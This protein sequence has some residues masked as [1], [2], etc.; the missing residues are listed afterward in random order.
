VIAW[1]PKRGGTLV[2]NPHFRATRS[3]AEGYPD[4]IEI[5]VFEEPTVEKR[6]EAVQR[7]AADVTVVANPF[8]SPVSARRL[9]AL[10]AQ[11]PGRVHSDP[12]L[13]SEWM[14]LN[15]RRRPFDDP[16]VRKAV[17]FA[18]DRQR[19]VELAGGEEVGGPTCQILPRAFP[20]Y[21]PYCPYS[22]RPAPGRG[23]TAPDMER[24]RRLVAA[25]GRVGD[26][27]VVH[28][29]DFDY[30]VR[31]A[32]YYARRL[33]ELGFRTTLRIQ[34]FDAYDVYD[35]NT[36]A[37]TGEAQWGADYLAPANF[38][39]PNFGC[40]APSNASRLCDRTLDRRAARALEAPPADAAAAWAQADRRVVDL[41]A[42]VP[43]TNRRS[44]V[45]VSKRVGNVRSH[46]LLFTLLDQMWVR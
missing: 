31:L 9:R 13:T 37:S 6:I 8:N 34:S 22:A 17:N 11:A 27:V 2:R 10:S 30:K 14:F 18:I 46:P 43:L 36:R 35:A 5:G 41:A 38:I 45:L 12:A 20:G 24:A 21:E 15:V 40:G 23:W 4:R 26:R 7:G 28:M 25:S 44:V 3:R 33:R 39:Q 29:P 16:R 42:A 19:V 1:D 32:R